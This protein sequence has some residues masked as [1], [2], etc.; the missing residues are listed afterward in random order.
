MR[1]IGDTARKG[2]TTREAGRWKEKEQEGIRSKPNWIGQS[3]A[4]MNW[5]WNWGNGQTQGKGNAKPARYW[6]G[7]GWRGATN[8]GFCGRRGRRSTVAVLARSAGGE[9]HYVMRQDADADLLGSGQPP[10]YVT[11]Y[12]PSERATHPT[13]ATLTGS[14]VHQP[15]PAETIPP[16]PSTHSDPRSP[17]S[18]R[19]LSAHHHCFFQPARSVRTYHSSGT[20]QLTQF[21]QLTPLIP[22]SYHIRNLTLTSPPQRQHG[23]L[24][25]H[26]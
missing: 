2:Q 24:C 1:G 9:G 14:P 8:V 7:G 13:P 5:N 4:E 19:R 21:A 6:A 25:M 23:R 18:H 10:I 12:V 3:E 17:P 22:H 11:K 26:I 15:Y 20:S 16:R